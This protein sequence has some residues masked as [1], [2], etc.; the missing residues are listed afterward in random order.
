MKLLNTVMLSLHVVLVASEGCT[1]HSSKTLTGPAGTRPRA[2]TTT[3]A[4]GFRGSA[5]A[6]QATAAACFSSAKA[7]RARRASARRRRTATRRTG[8][9]SQTAA[10]AGTMCNAAIR[11][12]CLGRLRGASL[13]RDGDYN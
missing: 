7:P 5:R 12:L 4:T 2:S 10:E 1:Y 8:S 9:G 3:L 6:D 11:W 13:T